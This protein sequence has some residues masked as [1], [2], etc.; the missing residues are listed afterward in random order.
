MQNARA[1][2]KACTFSAVGRLSPDFIV[3]DGVVP[4]ARLARLATIERSRAHTGSAWPMCFTRVTGTFTRSF[5]TSR[6]AGAH[7]R[8]EVLA[9]EIYLSSVWEEE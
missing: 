5:Y 2:V 7:D 8:A 1:T 3:Q 6:E 9:A 4:R